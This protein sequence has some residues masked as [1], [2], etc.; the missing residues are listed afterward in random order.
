LIKDNERKMAGEMNKDILAG[1]EDADQY[2]EESRG[3]KKKSFKKLQ[4]E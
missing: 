2:L 3:E 1:S 4:K